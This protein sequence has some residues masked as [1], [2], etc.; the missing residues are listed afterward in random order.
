ME[1][2]EV[3]GRKV[4]VKEFRAKAPIAEKSS[5][6]IFLPVKNKGCSSQKRK[7]FRVYL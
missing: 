1:L 2:L 4:R 7:M 5:Y 6:T 3:K